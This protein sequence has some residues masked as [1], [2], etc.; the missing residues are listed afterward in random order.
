MVDH[1][2]QLRGESV[3]QQADFFFHLLCTQGMYRGDLRAHV[4]HRLQGLV[5][6]GDARVGF[7]GVARFETCIV[8]NGVDTLPGFQVREALICLYTMTPDNHFI[9]DHHPRLPGVVFATGFSGHGFKFAPVVGEV[10][11]DLALDGTTAQP[12]SFLSAGRF[13]A[14]VTEPA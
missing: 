8:G 9:I 5:Q 4:Q 6:G 14:P 1:L 10:L 2:E 12:I 13:Q 11:A 3:L 7:S